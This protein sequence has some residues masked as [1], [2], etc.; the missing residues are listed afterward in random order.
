MVDRRWAVRL[1]LGGMIAGL[2]ACS[3]GPGAPPAP[4]A[5][6]PAVLSDGP[7]RASGSKCPAPMVS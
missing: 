5:L 6:P 4:E 3:D 7:N 2:A 1:T